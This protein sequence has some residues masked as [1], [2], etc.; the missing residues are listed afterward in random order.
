MKKLYTIA[1]N[2]MIFG[3]KIGAAFN[4]KLKKGLAGRRRA[5]EDVQE[6]ISKDDRVIWMHASSLGEYEQGLPVLEQLKKHYPQHKI[7]ITFFSPSGYENLVTRQHIA[8]AVAYLPFDVEK[9]IKEFTSNFHT[10]IFFTV[11]YDYWY[12]LL[13]HLR[14][15]GAR[16]YVVSALFYETQIF[17][18]AYGKWFVKQLSDSVDW[19]FHQTAHS[20]A[21]AKGLGLTKS[22]TSGDT[23][24]DR[25]KNQHACDNY[26]PYIKE[27]CQDKTTVVFGSCWEDE[28]RIAEILC[29]GNK[30]AKIILAPHDLKRVAHLRKIFPTAVLYSELQAIGEKHCADCGE[31][32]AKELPPHV[33][34]LAQILIIDCI[35]LLSKLY[36]YGDIAVVGGGF[37]SAGLH[38]I[39]EAAT[40]G[41]PVLFGNK[42]KEKPEADAL[43]AAGGA[44]SFEDEFFAGNYLLNLITQPQI[45]KEMGDKAKHFIFSQ[46]DATS[47]IVKKIVADTK[48][49][50]SL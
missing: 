25:V 48:A 32:P 42:Y 1:I 47:I 49:H 43:I 33:V 39:L 15:K 50:I 5:C 4:Y 28:E 27:F 9:W 44:K 40:F 7:L 21:L 23:R 11:K 36:S 10:D 16:I 13:S 20:S 45:F 6:S 29:S 12:H 22:S 3:M 2:L 38:N 41:I 35:G 37:H 24:Y 8:D 34:P 26:V 30:S 19:F 46:P 17:F 18:S 14:A 31:D